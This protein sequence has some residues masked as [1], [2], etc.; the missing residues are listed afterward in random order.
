MVRLIFCLYITASNVSQWWVSQWRRRRRLI[1]SLPARPG[2]HPMPPCRNIWWSDLIEPAVVEDERGPAKVGLQPQSSD[3]DVISWRASWDD[4]QL[5]IGSKL[6]RKSTKD[7]FEGTV[8]THK[9]S[10]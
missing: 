4:W 9:K 2:M 5:S 3:L 8:T 10:V 1:D 6:M 7:D